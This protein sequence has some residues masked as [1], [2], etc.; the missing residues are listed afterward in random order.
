MIKHLKTVGNDERSNKR[1]SLRIRLTSIVGFLILTSVCYK[2]I[3]TKNSSQEISI[4]KLRSLLIYENMLTGI[5]LVRPVVSAQ[6]N[7]KIR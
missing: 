5:V 1:F 3:V 4:V 2:N 6:Q 7:T